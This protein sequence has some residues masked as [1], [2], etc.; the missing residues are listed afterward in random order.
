M[1]LTSSV[2]LL[3]L[4]LL[5]VVVVVVVVVVNIFMY[6]LFS[7]GVNNSMYSI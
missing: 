3:L 2:H 5:L 7:D 1:E 6:K 4:L